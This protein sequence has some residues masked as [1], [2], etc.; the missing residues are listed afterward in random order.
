MFQMVLRAFLDDVFNGLFYP[1]TLE[2]FYK[3]FMYCNWR[4]GL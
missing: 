4:D 1:L 2:K 3:I